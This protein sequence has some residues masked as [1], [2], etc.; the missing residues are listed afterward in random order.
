MLD[1]ANLNVDNNCAAKTTTSSTTSSS[2]TS[3][4]TSSSTT[5]TTSSKDQTIVLS[6][7]TELTSFSITEEL[8]RIATTIA[9]Q[10]P[11][12]TTA[13]ASRFFS[14]SSSLQSTN[15]MDPCLVNR[16]G[17]N[18][19]CVSTEVNFYCKCD[20][21]FFGDP[22]NQCFAD[23]GDTQEVVAQSI[24][25]KIEFNELLL[26]NNTELFR[27]YKKGFQALLEPVFLQKTEYIHNSLQVIRFRYL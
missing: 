6:N 10:V 26:E 15:K 14:S 4:T 12:I 7:T 3:S 8:N 5:S 13:N 22:S 1:I 18:A 2:T 9:E 21:G 11:E 23:T 17:K 19:L 27:K 16:C 25:L 24:S 20:S